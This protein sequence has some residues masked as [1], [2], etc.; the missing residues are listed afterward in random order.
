MDL[1][2]W[3]NVFLDQL[4]LK[5]RKQATIR[6]YDY[7]LLDFFQWLEEK[8]FH[9]LTTEEVEAFY[10]HLLMSRQYK[11]RTIRR[12]SSVLRRF[13]LF[14]L[15]EGFLQDHPLLHHEP[16][17]L[18]LEPLNR[19]EWISQKETSI[20]LKTSHS[21]RGLTEN[22]RIARP[23]LTER[24]YTILLLLTNYGITLSEACALTM[25]DTSFIQQ[26]II[27]GLDASKRTL[28][29]EDDHAKQLYVYW[30]SIPEPVRPR[31]H[32]DDSFFVAFDF[33]RRTYHWSYENDR[34]KALTAIALQ[35]MIRTEVA[36][37]HLR[38]GISAQH[39]RNSYL[40]RSLLH[41]GHDH[42]LQRKLGLKS[43]LSLRRYV[44][45][46]SRLTTKEKALLLPNQ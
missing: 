23:Q 45:T 43:P 3:K 18:N 37:A 38:K 8:P 34:P 36:R 46:V 24:N 33:T 21:E 35:K 28:T 30:S 41:S 11:V 26:T 14:L 1:L 5:G 44:L 25:R 22:Q 13:A 29:L 15:E 10:H 17:L 40:L 31:M 12:I 7:D 19:N 16:P 32:T 20:L 6:R 42:Q 2:S 4:A 39:F 9:T 27:V